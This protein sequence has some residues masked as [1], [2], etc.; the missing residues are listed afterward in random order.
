MSCD[1]SDDN[2]DCFRL[3]PGDRSLAGTTQQGRDFMFAVLRE[4]DVGGRRFLLGA[5]SSSDAR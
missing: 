1:C 4:V 3:P 5:V 2:P